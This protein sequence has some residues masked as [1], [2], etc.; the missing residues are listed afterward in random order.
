MRPEV[1]RLAMALMIAF[2][3]SLMAVTPAMAYDNSPASATM[4]FEGTLTDNGDGVYTGTIEATKGTYWAVGGPGYA[5]RRV[6]SEP[7]GATD[8]DKG[9]WDIYADSTKQVYHYREAD[10]PAQQY[11]VG[12]DHDPYDTYS[13]ISESHD[14]DVADWCS[15][16]LELTS[17]H[18]YLRHD[19]ANQSPMSGSLTWNGDGTGYAK[20]TDLGTQFGGHGGSSAHGGGAR[21]WDADWFWGI[22]VVPLQYPGFDIQVE[23]LGGDTYHVTMTPAQEDNGGG[24]F[25]A[26]AAYGSYLD[27]HVDTLRSFRDGFLENEFVSAYYKVSPPIA[28]FIDA[29]PAFKPAVRAALMPAVGVSEVAVGMGLASKVGVAMSAPLISGLGLFWLRRRIRES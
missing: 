26:T 21:A 22:E 2:C 13:P 6:T 5:S 1:G 10:P 28:D 9:G 12:S 8:N 19:T 25:I 17:G 24:C 27:N 14:P 15:Y 3:L 16:S 4:H 23:D 7:C 20:E 11:D 18:W 29:H